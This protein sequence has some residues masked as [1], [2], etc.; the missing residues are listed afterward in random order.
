M[1]F[2][3][4]FISCYSNLLLFV[5]FFLIDGKICGLIGVFFFWDLGSLL[6]L[7]FYFFRYCGLCIDKDWELNFLL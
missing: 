5:L 7:V 4:V 6:F 3:I 2:R 1:K